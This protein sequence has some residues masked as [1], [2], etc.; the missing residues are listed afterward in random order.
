[1]DQETKSYGYDS[2]T[3]EIIIN[4]SIRISKQSWFELKKHVKKTTTWKYQDD[5]TLTLD[6]KKIKELKVVLD[7]SSELFAEV[8]VGRLVMRAY[9]FQKPVTSFEIYNNNFERITQL[10]QNLEKFFFVKYMPATKD[11][12][13]IH[14]SRFKF[15]FEE[16]L[17]TLAKISENESLATDNYADLLGLYYGRDSYEL[18][19]YCSKKRMKTYNLIK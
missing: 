15:I 17:K 7:N 12:G 6:E 18:A 1:M 2:T 11:S 8:G 4:D 9:K 10:I 3:D 13:E 5:S 19:Q 14:I 16:A